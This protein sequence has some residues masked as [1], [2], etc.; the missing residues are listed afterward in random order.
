MQFIFLRRARPPQS[1][2][3][4]LAS[5]LGRVPW[6]KNLND[7]LLQEVYE[8]LVGKGA[9]SMRRDPLQRVRDECVPMGSF[10]VEQ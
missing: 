9:V 7:T 6:C 1:P 5:A 2:R 10:G 4:E 8:L 3:A